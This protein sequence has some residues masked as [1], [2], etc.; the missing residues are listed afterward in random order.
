MAVILETCYL[1]GEFQDIVSAKIPV[2]DRGFIF[3]DAVY[4]VIPVYAG[5]T[6]ALDLHL[7]RLERSLAEISLPSPMDFAQWREVIYELI[8][9]NGGADQSLYLQVSRGV[10]PRNHVIPENISPTVFIFSQQFEPT[11]QVGV[12]AITDIDIRWQ[13]CDIKATS[14]LANVILRSRANTAGAYETIL[15]RDGMLTEGAASNVFIVYNDRI[16][17]PIEDHRILAGITRRLLIDSLNGTD[18]AVIEQDV[19]AEMFESATEIWV[20][21]SSRDLSPVLKC[22]GQP[23]GNGE[24]GS[25]FVEA[26]QRFLQWKN[27]QIA[28]ERKNRQLALN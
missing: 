20:S 25:K 4:E 2:L 6:L 7:E 26:E 11:K 28:I 23:V 3:G 19:S 10:A 22:N 1:N 14:L 15:F 21:S 27:N 12:E 24:I 13:R 18:L 17:T 5:I 8:A 9:Q 16:V